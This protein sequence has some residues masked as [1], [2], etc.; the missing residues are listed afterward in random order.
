[1][2]CTVLTPPTIQTRSV[3]DGSIIFF[4]WHRRG[5]RG[6]R[7]SSSSSSSDDNNNKNNKHKKEEDEAV[8]RTGHKSCSGGGHHVGRPSTTSK[9]FDTLRCR[10]WICGGFLVGVHWTSGIGSGR[11]LPVGGA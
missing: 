6:G 3:A 7:D 1:M 5:E 11:L 2:P 8:P 4:A 9:H 10:R